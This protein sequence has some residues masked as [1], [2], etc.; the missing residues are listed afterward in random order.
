MKHPQTKL[1]ADTTSDSKVTR[2]RK[3][4]FIIRSK[5]IVR[6]KF[7]AEHL[8][9]FIDILSKLQQQMLTCFCKV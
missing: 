1:H 4:E 7:L 6:W 5:F 2:L 3:S 9:L 8:L